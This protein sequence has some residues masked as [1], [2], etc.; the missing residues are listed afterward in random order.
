[1]GGCESY[2]AAS[3]DRKTELHDGEPTQD[4]KLRVSESKSL[5]ASTLV[6]PYTEKSYLE[7]FSILG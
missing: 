3:E 1:M 2:C 6:S 7:Y 5:S 4:N